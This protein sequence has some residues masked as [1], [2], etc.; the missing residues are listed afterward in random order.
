MSPDKSAFAQ[1]LAQPSDAAKDSHDAFAILESRRNL[2]SAATL[3]DVRTP[4]WMR[5]STQALTSPDAAHG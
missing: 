3:S 5:P 1:T 2:Y 4:T